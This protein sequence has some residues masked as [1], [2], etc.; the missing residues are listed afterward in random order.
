MASIIPSVCSATA[1]A[2]APG[3]IHHRDAFMRGRFQID[4]VH[5]HARAP[6]HPQLLRVLQQLGIRLHGRAHDQRIG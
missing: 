1:T 3:R 2:L 4:V 6:D 5:A